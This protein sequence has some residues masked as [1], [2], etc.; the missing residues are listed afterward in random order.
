MLEGHER[1]AMHVQAPQGW[2]HILK[3]EGPV[4]VRSQ[5][6]GV[7]MGQERANRVAM[8]DKAMLV[9]RMEAAAARSRQGLLPGLSWWWEGNPPGREGWWREDPSEGARLLTPQEVEPQTQQPAPNQQQLLGL[10]IYLL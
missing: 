7:L 4:R 2:L 10:D 6:V 5:E 8:Q 3:L 9:V 1:Q